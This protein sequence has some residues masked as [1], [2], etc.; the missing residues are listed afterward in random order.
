MPSKR[1]A[2]IR[3]NP[4]ESVFEIRPTLSL[5][6]SRTPQRA[7]TERNDHTTAMKYLLALLAILAA[8]N[9]AANAQPGAKPIP[10]RIVTQLGDIDAELDSARAPVTVTNFLRYI[11][12]HLFDGGTF[13]RTVTMSNQPNDSVR[14]QVIQGGI[15]NAKLTQGFPA[16]PLERTSA[17][18]L[19]HGD[20]ALSMARSVPNS[21]TGSFFITIGD[22][23]ALD[24]AGKRQ[25]DGQGFAAFGHVTKGL[26]VVRKIQSQPANGQSII[27][28]VTILRIVR[29]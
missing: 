29:L 26:D 18:G 1:S 10:I 11:D 16:I 25:P 6:H 24:F 21:A 4:R 9:G 12:A 5:T 2:Y 7:K 28:P 20:G 23:P 8:A 15:P 27:A 17:T 22:Q 14:I 3:Q 19:H 13:F